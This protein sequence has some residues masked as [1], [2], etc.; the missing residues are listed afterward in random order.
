V[1]SREASDNYQG[2]QYQEAE[3][4]IGSCGACHESSRG[5]G[6][7]GEDDEFGEEHGG[8]DPERRTACH[9]CHTAVPTSTSSWPHAYE[10]NAH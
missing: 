5:G 8:S 6:E 7:D 10:W 1:P 4:T 9:V 2:E 3:V